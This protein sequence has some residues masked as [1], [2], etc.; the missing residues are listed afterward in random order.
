MPKKIAVIL[1]GCGYLDG[2]EIHESVLTLTA[3]DAHQAEVAIFAPNQN[4]F[5]VVNHMIGDEC[6]DERNILEESSRIARGNIK[7]LDKLNARDFDGIIF[8]GGFGVVKNLCNW[9]YQGSECIIDTKVEEVIKNFYELKKP[10]AAICIAPALIATVLG[11]QKIR[12]TIG[13]DEITSKEIEKTGAEHEVKEVH[14]ICID[15]PHKI[16]TTPGYMYDQAKLDKIYEGI[17]SCVKAL[18]ELS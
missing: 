15:K 9:A 6:D 3:L 7:N 2:S 4:Q 18:L 13:N 8:P 14:E 11:K 12:V 17:S 10:I 16:I 1:S 5:H